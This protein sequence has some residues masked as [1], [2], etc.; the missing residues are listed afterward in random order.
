MSELDVRIIKLE[1]MRVAS[2]YG[3]GEQP[4]TEAW[5][6]LVAWGE[7][8][9]YLDEHKKHRTRI[10]GFNNPDPFAWQPKLWL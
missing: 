1:P 7:P 10:F 4:E 5:E 6:K 8:K 2:L 3:F 9:G